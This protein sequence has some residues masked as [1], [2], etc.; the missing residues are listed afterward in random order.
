VIR[1]S[2]CSL[3][4]RGRHLWS[5]FLQAVVGQ[6][7]FHAADADRPSGLNEFLGDDLRR[8]I[9]VEE[10]VPDHLADD[11]GRTPIVPLGAAF[12][13]VQ[14]QR[15][16][17]AEGGA[18]LEVALLAVAELFGGLERSQA[19]ALTFDKHQQFAGDLILGG[20]FKPA[21]WPDQGMS[22]QIELCHGCLLRTG[23]SL[24]G[25]SAGRFLRRRIP[26][27]RP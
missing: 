21:P 6:D 15:A 26:Q 13:A 14:S 24:S 20:Y 16:P 23:R 9:G 7:A 12:L 8:R 2:T 3:S 5:F 19:F 22:L 17:F 1:A 18:E 10:A 11:L 4:G 27:D 25:R